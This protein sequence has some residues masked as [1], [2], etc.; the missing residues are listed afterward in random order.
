MAASKIISALEAMNEL[1]GDYPM[2]ELQYTTPFQLLVAVLLSAQ[3]TDKQVN[4]VTAEFFKK[5]RTPEDILQLWEEEVGQYIKTVGLHIAKKKNLM[6][7]SQQLVDLKEIKQKDLPQAIHKITK[8]DRS[9]HVPYGSWLEVYRQ[10]GYIIP[11]S[12]EELLLLAWVG[13]KTAKVLLNVLYGKK[14]VAV[15]THVHRVMNRLWIVHTI[16]PDRTSILLETGIPDEYKDMAH[17]VIIYFWRYL[18]KA[19]K[20]ECYRCPLTDMCERYKENILN[21]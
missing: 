13:I 3:T 1:F 20:P 2:T 18:C 21:K 14:Q 12:L 10:R 8:K 9:L 5:V 6:K 7:L 11:D 15:D 17:K 4:K 19:Q 16:S